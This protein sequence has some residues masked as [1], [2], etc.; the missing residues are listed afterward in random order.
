MSI[1]GICA[2]IVA[3]ATMMMFLLVMRI[4]TPETPQQHELFY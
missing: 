4:N 1:L 2:A 3:I